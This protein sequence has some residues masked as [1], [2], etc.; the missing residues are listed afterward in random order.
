ML[1]AG[2]GSRLKTAAG[3]LP[4]ALLTVGGRSVL[5]RQLEALSDVGVPPSAVT[6]VG[7]WRASEL[8]RRMPGEAGLV[9]NPRWADTDTLAS[10]MAGL[11]EGDDVLVLHGDLVLRPDLLRRTLEGAGDVVIP[12]DALSADAEAMKVHLRD[13]G[14]WRLS[15]EPGDGCAGESMGVFLIRRRA[16]PAFLREGRGILASAPRA[17]AD[18]VV[19]ALARSP[20]TEVATVDVTGC[21]WEEVDTPGDLERAREIFGSAGTWN[22]VW[23]ELDTRPGDGLLH[24]AGRWLA[25][26]G[27]LQRLVVELLFRRD[28]RAV[29][30]VLEAGCGSGIV[31]QEVDRRADAAGFD[32]S[33]RAVEMTRRRGLAVFRGD[34][35]VPPLAPGCADTVYSVGVLDQLSEEELPIALKGLCGAVAPGGR[36]L[37]V[38]ASSRS[39]LH[40]AVKRR[41]IRRGEW[42]FGSKRAF[43]SL[44]APVR[45]ACP[46]AVV[47]ERHMGLLIG[48][49]T[50][51][52]LA[53]RR[54]AARRLVHGAALT[55]SALLWPLN[56]LPGMVLVTDIRTPKG[57]GG[58]A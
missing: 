46:G 31:L 40:E 39:R 35:T 33:P 19:T 17:A 11:R 55:L 3:G 23:E 44:K 53:W 4:K 10:L 49:R 30:R 12:V 36:L 47:F 57:D 32:L 45:A 14:V 18:D 24:R 13:G 43:E 16:L 48:L 42:P 41:L 29:G 52:Y 8:R 5:D 22:G 58:A 21:D 54:P 56:R 6:V 51:G 9:E 7:G 26:R 1:A 34:V 25:A 38:T 2:R 37:L 20:G 27:D 28:G 15:K 50:L